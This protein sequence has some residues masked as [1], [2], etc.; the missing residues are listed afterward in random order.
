[1][2]LACIG[3]G[4]MASALLQGRER[5]PELSAVHIVEPQE[6]SRKRLQADGLQAYATPAELPEGIEGVLLCVKPQ[7]MRQ[8]CGELAEHVALEQLPV[9]SIAAGVTIAQLRSWLGG[10][11]IVRTMPNTP[12]R[13]GKGCTFACAANEQAAAAAA[14]PLQL[15]AAAGLLLWVKDEE[16]LDAATALSGS[17]P[18]YVYLLIETMAASAREMGLEPEDALA[19]TLAT[20]SGAAAMV[21]QTGTDPAELRRQVTSKG[22]TTQAAL[23]A[24]EQAGFGPALAEAMRAAQQ[25]AAELAAGQQ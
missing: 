24:L 13:I 6:A 11:L 25:R 2:K 1:M 20:V 9:V 14:I 5:V 8:A 23:A 18:A 7:D 10:G 3:G 21:E 15:F 16:L 19:A 22:G 17:G 12:L 4:V